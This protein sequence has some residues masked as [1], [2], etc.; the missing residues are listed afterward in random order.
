MAADQFFARE[1]QQGLGDRMLLE[2]AATAGGDHSVGWRALH[3]GVMLGCDSIEVRE[4]K[5]KREKI[6]QMLTQPSF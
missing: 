6:I 4:I 2:L 3:Q 1:V 5:S